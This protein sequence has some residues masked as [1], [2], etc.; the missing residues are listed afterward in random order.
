MSTEKTYSIEEVKEHG[1]K[2]IAEQ[3]E[4]LKQNL[5]EKRKDKEY[6]HV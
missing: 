2:I 4:I 6:S 1:K 3:A 5:R